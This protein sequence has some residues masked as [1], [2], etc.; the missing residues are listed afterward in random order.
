MIESIPFEFSHALHLD[1]N[2][3]FEDKKELI[4]AYLRTEGFKMETL[5][6]RE[7]GDVLAVFSGTLVTAN[8]FE[9]S[10]LVG[11][12]AR[13]YPLQFFRH[14]ARRIDFWQR[15]MNVQRLQTT[16]R[17]NH[18]FLIKWIKLLGF[19]LEARMRKFGP[20]GDDYFLFARVR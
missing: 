4:G 8:T 13:K 1:L 7:T 5:V 2:E 10:A 3:A 15:T 16:I 18:P 11:A 19:S 17:D 12:N 20:E 6:H 9:I 14:T